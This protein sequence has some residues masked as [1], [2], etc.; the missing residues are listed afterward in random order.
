MRILSLDISSSTGW[1]F[2]STQEGPSSLQYGCIALPKRA[3]DYAKHPWGYYSAANALAKLLGE[4]IT[5]LSPLDVIVVEETNGGGRSSRWSQKFLEYCHFAFL[6]RYHSLWYDL[7]DVDL[8][9]DMSKLVY[10]NTSEWRRVTETK[11]S[12]E[13]KNRNARLSRHRRAAWAVGKK[14]S[15][16]EKQ[17]IGIAGKTTIKHVAIRR[18]RELYGIDLLAKDDDP[19]DAI[20][21]LHSYINGAKPCTGSEQR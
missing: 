11:L 13:D 18:V 14:L 2:L 4:K 10:I 5:E 20:L 15:Y 16:Q 1:A 7:Q 12:K 21:L 3:R 9:S 6:K 19:A 8:P 17:A